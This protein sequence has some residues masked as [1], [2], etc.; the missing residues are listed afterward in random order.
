MGKFLSHSHTHKQSIIQNIKRRLN[1]SLT[2][3]VKRM[4]VEKLKIPRL[5]SSLPIRLSDKE[6]FQ[7]ILTEEINHSAFY[8]EASKVQKVQNLKF[9]SQCSEILNF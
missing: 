9:P 2:Y 8:T 7:E 4:L 1:N 6:I 3:G 5:Y